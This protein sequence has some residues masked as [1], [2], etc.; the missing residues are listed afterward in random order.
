L[1]RKYAHTIE[2]N[3]QGGITLKTL[4]NEYQNGTL[5]AALNQMETKEIIKSFKANCFG[6]PSRSRE[7]VIQQFMSAMEKAMNKGNAFMR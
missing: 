7:K 6:I 3:Q 1:K 4:F 5:E 2:Y